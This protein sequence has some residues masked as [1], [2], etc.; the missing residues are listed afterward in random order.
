MSYQ[1]RRRI[2]KKFTWADWAELTA[3]VYG[4]CGPHFPYTK[5]QKQNLLTKAHKLGLV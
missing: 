2:I 5:Q 1:E 4:W 3:K